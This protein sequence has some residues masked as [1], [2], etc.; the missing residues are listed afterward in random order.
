[1]LDLVIHNGTVVLPDRI[2]QMNI[3]D[4]CYDYQ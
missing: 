4:M 1:M 3:G 2:A